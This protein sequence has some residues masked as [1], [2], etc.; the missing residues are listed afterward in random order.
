M[1][2]DPDTESRMWRGPESETERE[3]EMALEVRMWA[4]AGAG[5]FAAGWTGWAV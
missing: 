1:D 3:E 5:V 4:F 2:E